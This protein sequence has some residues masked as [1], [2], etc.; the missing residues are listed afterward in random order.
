MA[1]QQEIIGIVQSFLKEA[2]PGEF[3]EVVSGSL[4]LVFN[5]VITTLGVY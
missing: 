4:S 2:P 1:S 3:M 5:Y